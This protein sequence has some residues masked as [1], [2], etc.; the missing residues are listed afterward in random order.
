MRAASSGCL[1]VRAFRAEAAAS[2][3]PAGGAASGT[4]A[5]AVI[6]L[7]SNS[8]DPTN[9]R[10]RMGPPGR[11]TYTVMTSR[12]PAVVRGMAGL[13]GNEDAAAGGGHR[14]VG[15]KRRL[16]R[17]AVAGRL[18]HLGAQDDRKRR[19]RGLLQLDVE[20]GS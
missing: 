3:S 18:H 2:A 8:R 17:G 6:A 4:A 7:A 10:A 1:A 11:C 20:L 9:G 16:H 19:R 15:R 13:D 5:G 14:T 12:L